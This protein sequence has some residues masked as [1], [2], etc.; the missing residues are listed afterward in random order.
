LFEGFSFRG[1]FLI[2]LKSTYFKSIVNKFLTKRRFYLI[3]GV[4]NIENKPNFIKSF[5]A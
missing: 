1:A 4:F 5:I 2:S 3:N